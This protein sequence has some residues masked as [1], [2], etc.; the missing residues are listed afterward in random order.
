MTPLASLFAA[1][2]SLI[3]VD[4][5]GDDPYL[6]DA[7][8]KGGVETNR[9]SLAAAQGEI[10]T[11]S[12]S[13][14]PER[15]MRKV[16]FKPS[17]LTGPGGAVIPAD[18][19]DFALVKVWYR[20]G[21]RWT[22]SWCGQTGKP[23]L[24]PD[25]ILHDDDLIRVDEQAT[26][27]LLR[28]DYP[29]GPAY[30]DIRH[31]GRDSHFQHDL[32]PVR[33]SK[34]FVPFDLKKDRYQQYWLTYRVPKDAKPGMYRGKVAVV[35]DGKPLCDL[36]VEIEVYPF[37]LPRARTHYDTTQDYL[38]IWMGTPTIQGLLKGS[39]RLDVAEAKA[40]A[41]YRSLVEHNALNSGSPGDY[42]SDS[43]DDLAVRSLL[44]MREEGM[45][46]KPMVNGP[47]ADFW[48]VCP[49]EGP[50]YSVEEY[51]DKY[52]AALKKHR[53]LVDRHVAVM[54]KYLGHREC[55]FT[56]ADECD[57]GTNRRS[58]G[59]WNY[60]HSKGCFT[61]TDA[62]VEQDIGA[63]VGMNDIGAACIHSEAWR[64][65]VG[66]AKAVTYAGTFTGPSCPSLWRRHKGIRYYYADYDGEHEYNFF[67][68]RR[69]RWN[70]FVWHGDYCQF[71]IVYFTYD[72]LISTLAWEGVR[73]GLDDIRYLSLLR[74]RAE[75]A[76]KSDDP[77]IRA[78]GR[79]EYLWMDSIDP[80]RVLDL[81]AFR[82]EV[83]RRIT[84]LI[85]KVGPQPPDPPMPKPA[86]PLP[87]ESPRAPV[88]PEQRMKVAAQYEK[89]DRWDLAMPILSAVRNDASRP[90]DERVA[91]ALKESELH[92]GILERKAAVAIVDEALG[93]KD[94]TRAQRGRLLLR[95]VEALMTDVI[96]EERYT[97]AQLDEAAAVIEEALKMPGVTT[98]ERY[99]AIIR[100]LRGYEAAG[101]HKA[102]IAYC[103]ARMADAGL[104]D[105]E[106]AEMILV[107]ADAY[108][109]MGENES[110]CKMFDRAHKLCKNYNDRGWKLKTLLKEARAAEACKD[111]QRAYRCYADVAI[112]YNNEEGD[113][114][115]SAVSHMNRVAKYIKTNAPT[116]DPEDDSGEP[117]IELDE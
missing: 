74:M 60:I 104:S 5:Y 17:E 98:Q 75:A 4:P 66:G 67:D 87:P 92:S 35:E 45:T 54:D 99:D 76:M 58:Y 40:R 6:P 93:W 83:A 3:W 50:T 91:A 33:D 108:I 57:T 56:S 116:V 29:D 71:G 117:A 68:G 51:P 11:I 97:R 55:Y 49:S 113:L 27:L 18:A 96:F 8:P 47:A 14:H 42:K 65:H 110:A 25:L 21:G 34:K 72:G 105:V 78:L 111:W 109:A 62:G 26:N 30:V 101:E 81:H 107:K 1:A 102:A 63:I 10:E 32:H 44:M 19:A 28:I 12:F 37:E 15:D 31:R 115:R 53:A 79:R 61:W 73:E 48:W 64:W 82:R 85:A 16:D 24:I 59:F 36:P 90:V 77:A 7:F 95:K 13:V 106:H 114:K 69:N 94:T 20:A 23:T 52:E 103:D 2:F 38:S 89:E 39:K 86:I 100:M 112:V 22:T 43:T 46:C 70:D 80:E 41:I 84:N 9:L 88:P